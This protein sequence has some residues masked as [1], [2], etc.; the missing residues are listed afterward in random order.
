MQYHK[1]DFSLMNV[2]S[3]ITFGFNKLFSFEVKK[4]ILDLEGY[5]HGFS[6]SGQDLS[7]PFAQIEVCTDKS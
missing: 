5:T 6:E 1:S 4:V 3:V 2:F 7:F